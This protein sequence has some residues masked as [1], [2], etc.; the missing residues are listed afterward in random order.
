MLC[1]FC[2]WLIFPVGRDEGVLVKGSCTTFLDVNIS[3][4]SAAVSS[5]GPEIGKEE[6]SPKRGAMTMVE[7]VLES[8][9]AVDR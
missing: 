1:K 9:T 4:L 5:V 8:E 3:L 7:A 6:V 2:C